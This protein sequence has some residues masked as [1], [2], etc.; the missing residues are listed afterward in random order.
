MNI[1]D[2]F[3]SKIRMKILTVLNNMGELNVSE[4]ARRLRINY[5]S[6]SKHVQTL[7]GEGIVQHKMFGRIRLYRMNEQSAKAKAVQNLIDVW[8]HQNT[9]WKENRH[10]DG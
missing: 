5:V 9:K 4:I 7:E 10:G 6:A 1:E 8:E 3:C 2:V